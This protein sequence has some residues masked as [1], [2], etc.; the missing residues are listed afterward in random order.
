MIVEL[1]PAVKN[2]LLN[3]DGI[4]YHHQDER[5]GRVFWRCRHYPR[6]KGRATTQSNMGHGEVK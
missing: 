5:K 6:C 3:I 2:Y 1:I 4:I